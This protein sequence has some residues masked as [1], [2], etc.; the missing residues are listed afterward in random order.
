MSDKE[1]LP[2]EE[3]EPGKQ[4]KKSSTIKTVLFGAIISAT[5]GGAAAAGVYF[6]APDPSACVT[7][8]SVAKDGHKSAPE[9]RDVIFV[10]LE[11]LVVTLGPSAKSKYLKISVSLETT[12]DYEKS[13]NELTPRFRDV[14][15]SYLRAVDEK[16]LI[17]PAAMS[18][19]R[20]QMLRRLQV[21]APEDSVTDVLITDF[22]LT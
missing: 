18:R 6:F 5:M 12:H 21:V 11:P 14:L 13:V 2:A 22:V 4:N 8:A 10:N 16:D 7:D 1:D 9:P 19:L 3:E 17:I 15:N 20:A